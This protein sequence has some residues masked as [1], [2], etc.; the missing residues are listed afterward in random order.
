MLKFV[1]GILPALVIQTDNMPAKFGG[2]SNAML[3]RIRPKYAA[4]TGLLNHE[5]THVKQ[6]YRT[7]GLHSILYPLVAKYRLYAEVEAHA[8]Q[9]G[10]YATE[11]D[12]MRAVDSLATKYDLPMS[13]AYI[14]GYLLQKL[15]TLFGR[16]MP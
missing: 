10:K 1:Y 16:L 11:W 4:D 3:V 14:Q 6:F 12:I 15:H 7:L 13:K 5:L 9:I 8:V 2:C